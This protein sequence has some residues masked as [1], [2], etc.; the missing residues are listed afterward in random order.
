M[1]NKLYWG[2]ALVAI[3]IIGIAFSSGDQPTDNS[4]LP[5]H[6]T[7]PS[8]NTI[9][10]FGV[11][12]GKSNAQEAEQHF[13]EAAKPIL[14]KSP[15]GKFVVEVFFEDVTLAKLKARIVLTIAVPENEL[16]DLF[17]RG[18]RMNATRSGKEIT[19]TPKDIAHIFTLPITSL[20]YLPRVRLG[21][22]IFAKRFGEPAQRIKEKKSGAVHWLY[23]KQ[24]LDITLGGE[25]KPLLQFVEPK[26]FDQLLKPLLS[27]GERIK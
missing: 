10:V 24:G 19:L 13:K 12:L 9:R 7:H 1:E 25:E 8:P 27:K 17:E 6:I 20:T 16:H 21:D 4:D 2:V 22:A 11:T 23:P 3:L 14:F 15:T 5:W 18:I 26:N